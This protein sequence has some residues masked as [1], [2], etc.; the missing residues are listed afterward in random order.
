[1]TITDTLN[2]YEKALFKKV[3]LLSFSSESTQGLSLLS[4]YYCK[5]ASENNNASIKTVNLYN[6]PYDTSA[7]LTNLAVFAFPAFKA[8]TLNTFIFCVCSAVTI[9]IARVR[10]KSARCKFYKENN[11]NEWFL[12]VWKPIRISALHYH[13]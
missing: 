6:S 1:M 8:L 10:W 2:L 5:R 7:K 3:L 11:N 9:V 13:P 4:F 12:F